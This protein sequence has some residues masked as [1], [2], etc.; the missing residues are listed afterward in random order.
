MPLLKGVGNAPLENAS[1]SDAVCGPRPAFGARN[2]DGGKQGFLRRRKRWMQTGTGLEWLCGDIS[3][4]HK[5]QNQ[6]GAKRF[7][8]GASDFCHSRSTISKAIALTKRKPEVSRLYVPMRKRRVLC[9]GVRNGETFTDALLVPGRAVTTI[10][11]L[12]IFLPSPSV[13]RFAVMA[14]LLRCFVDIHRFVATC[15]E[16]AQSHKQ[17]LTTLRQA[18]ALNLM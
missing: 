11:S 13:W 15:R 3:A 2:I 4:D 16:L 14:L 18:A 1:P 12:T 8:C 5:C 10:P 9:A 17:S 7:L 6:Y